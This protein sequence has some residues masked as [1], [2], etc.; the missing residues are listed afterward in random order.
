[1]APVSHVGAMAPRA[2]MPAPHA[3]PV[4]AMPGPRMVA[5]GGAVGARTGTPVAPNTRGQIT[6]RRRF[7]KRFDKEDISP[8]RGCN[9]APGLG[10]D[11]GHQAAI[12][13]SG[14]GV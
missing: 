2:V 4:R 7:E 9:S 12:Y 10:F 5:R 14:I 13:G 6:T 1:M 11:A 3:M 8:R